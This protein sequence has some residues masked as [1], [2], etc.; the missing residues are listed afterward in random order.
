M[1]FSAGS[2][3]EKLGTQFHSKNGPSISHKRSSA[4]K[5]RS[6]NMENTLFNN[7]LGNL[8]HHM[9]LGIYLNKHGSM[10]S[11]QQSAQSISRS[12]SLNLLESTC[13]ETKQKQASSEIWFKQ[14]GTPAAEQANGQSVSQHGFRSL[15]QQKMAAPTRK[16]NVGDLFTE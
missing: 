4:L 16:G 11:I 8:S 14:H 1:N 12:Y 3:C 5:T 15:T 2:T 13:K 10:K 9:G 6:K 7:A